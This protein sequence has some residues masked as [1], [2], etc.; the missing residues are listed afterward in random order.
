VE[1]LALAGRPSARSVP[2]GGPLGPP[3]DEPFAKISNS[4]TCPAG[5]PLLAVM[6]SR[7]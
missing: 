3:P 1:P 2:A 6:F 7:R 4:E 5:Q